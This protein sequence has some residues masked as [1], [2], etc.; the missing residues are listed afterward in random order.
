[1]ARITNFTTLKAEV[2]NWMNRSDTSDAEV[3][4]FIQM[5]EVRLNRVLRVK[6]MEASATITTGTDGVG[7]LPS[8]F[9][10]FKV[11]YDA[12]RI[13]VPHVAPEAYVLTGTNDSK[14]YTILG[15]SLRLAPADDETLTAVYYKA[16]TPVTSSNATNW[17]LTAQPDLYLFGVLLAWS[18]V[19]V[20][21]E[22]IAKW[23]AAYNRTLGELMQSE[24]RDR[25]SGP[26]ARSTPVVQ[27]RG[28]RA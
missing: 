7:S 16:L 9:L 4:G 2:L 13:I 26:L 22:A 20:D 14:V 23:D 17:L 1:M 18:T 27:V 10:Q 11:V 8:G 5:A 15:G 24:R 6:E 19:I 3:E 21:D 25:Y 28:F 12:S